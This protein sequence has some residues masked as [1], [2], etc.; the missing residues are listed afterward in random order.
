[1]ADYFLGALKEI[2][3]RAQNNIL[4]FSDVLS[5][6]LDVIASNMEGKQMSDND[7][8]K[9]FELYYQRFSKEENKQAMLFC[10]LRMQ[11]IMFY[12]EHP[13]KQS[14]VRNME[15]NDSCDMVT[16]AFLE[17]KREYYQTTQLRIFQRFILLA[18]AAYIFFL[19]VGVLLFHLS[20]LLSFVFLLVAWIFALFVAK[21][22]GVPYF[23]QMQIE[24]LSKQVNGIVLKVDQT[25]F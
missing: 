6:R 5:G 9:L 16:K 10:L 24:N 22:V 2:E 25:V 20:F 18:S 4:V 14:E 17:R 15:F 3:R 7:Y 1:M 12:K 21:K 23:Y 19:I 13:E 8:L 11:Q